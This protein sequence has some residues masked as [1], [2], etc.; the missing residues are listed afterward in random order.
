MTLACESESGDLIVCVTH[1][2]VPYH[3]DLHETPRCQSGPPTA[4]STG[5]V[6]KFKDLSISKVY[7]EF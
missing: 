1:P 4:Q 6:N 2:P 5:S 7:V 3:A